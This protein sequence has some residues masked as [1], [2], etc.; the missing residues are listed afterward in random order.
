MRAARLRGLAGNEPPTNPPTQECGSCARSRLAL[1]T[2]SRPF[3]VRKA[4]DRMPEMAD[5]DS[6]ASGTGL[7]AVGPRTC[8]GIAGACDGCGPPRPG[9]RWTS[10]GARRFSSADL[11]K[12]VVASHRALRPGGCLVFGNRDRETQSWLTSP[13]SL[14]DLPLEAARRHTRR[15]DA[16]GSRRAL[17]GGE[18]NAEAT[19]AERSS[20]PHGDGCTRGAERTRDVRCRCRATT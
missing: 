16:R 15:V 10:S 8:S 1:A 11:G 12:N 20:S 5:Y 6:R 3:A 14:R 7:G 4:V 18:T 17:A 13:V 19:T 9:R 2:E